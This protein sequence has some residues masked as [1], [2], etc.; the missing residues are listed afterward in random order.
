MLSYHSLK[1]KASFSANRDGILRGC[2][3]PP[4][5]TAEQARKRIDPALPVM[6]FY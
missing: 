3:L 4:F 1:E 2:I 5:M 6:M